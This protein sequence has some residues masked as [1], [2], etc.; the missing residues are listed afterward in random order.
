MGS[1][2]VTPKRPRV[3]VEQA[4]ARGESTLDI[5]RR[6]DV[7]EAYVVSV[8]LKLD[9]VCDEPDQ[10]VHARRKPVV[11]A[12]R[13]MKPCGTYAAW[14]RHK[15]SGEK[16]CAPCQVARSEYRPDRNKRKTEVA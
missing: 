12:P 4:I 6:L 11:V 10:L 16:P 3:A 2:R 7:D 14:R 15:R 9:Q 8:W 1:L 13:T 5:C